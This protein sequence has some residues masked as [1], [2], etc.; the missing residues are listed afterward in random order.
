MLKKRLVYSTASI[1]IAQIFY[2]IKLI[3]L[4]ILS[5][6]FN[7]QEEGESIAKHA[8]TCLL[9]PYAAYDTVKQ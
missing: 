7:F 5:D 9:P 8:K 3:V 6:L 2:R 1:K 4:K